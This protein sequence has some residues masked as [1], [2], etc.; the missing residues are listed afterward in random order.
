MTAKPSLA[1][2][3]RHKVEQ[4]RE[5]LAGLESMR[6]ELL[7]RRDQLD[8]TLDRE[9]VRSKDSHIGR[10]AFPTFLKSVRDRQEN[11][12]RSADELVEQI[13]EVRE[14]HNA[15]LRELQTFENSERVELERKGLVA[16]SAPV[17]LGVEPLSATSQ[18][19]SVV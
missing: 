7:S 17:S 9:R 3:Q 10:V 13:M 16:P 12:Q 11:L 18:R 5:K 1:R 14:E 8:E 6:A 15:A 4:I 19:R 2:L